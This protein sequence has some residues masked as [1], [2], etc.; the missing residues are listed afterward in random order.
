MFALW[1]C[2]ETFALAAGDLPHFVTRSWQTDNGLPQSTATAVLQARDGYLWVGTYN[3]LMRYDGVRFVLFDYNNT[4]ELHDKGITCL[5]EAADGTLWIGHSSGGVTRYKNGHFER[6]EANISWGEGAIRAIAMDEMGD[7]WLLNDTG[8]LARLRDGLVLTPQTGPLNGMAQM[9][10]SEHGTI[11][12][13]RAG[14]LSQ[15]RASRLVVLEAG[16]ADN[17]VQ[18]V[19]VSR[20]G[21]LWVVSGGRLRQW[22]GG[23]WSED[24]G[25]VPS[26]L[27]P[28]AQL[29]E[30][31]DGWLAAA[32][33]DHG[34]YLSRPRAGENGVQFGRTNGFPSDWVTSL[35]EDRERDLWVGTAGAGLQVVRAAKVQTVSPPDQ[36]QGRA[37]LSVSTSGR[38]GALWI[39]SEG[40]GIYRFYE[41]T[42]KNFGVRAGLDNPYIWSV[43]EDEK[44]DLWAAS[45]GGGLYQRRND[46]FVTA[47]GLEGIVMPMAAI[48][49]SR[50]GGL[51]IGT[52]AGLL[53][54][55]DGQAT[56][57][58]QQGRP[59]GRSVRTVM[60]DS[61]GTVWFGTSGGGLGCLTNG[62]LR[63][64]RT[65]DGLASDYVTCLHRDDSGS[66]WIGTAGGLSRLKH[67][68][69]ATIKQK[70]GLP[71]EHICEIEEDGFGF[72][73]M[74]SHNGIIRV[75][76][77]D[78]DR[79][80]NGQTIKIT[81]L[82][83]GLGDGMPTLE[84]SGGLQP[85]GCKTSDGRLWFPT[86]KGLVTIE[87]RD[88]QTNSLPP[89]VVIESLTVDEKRVIEGAALL[90][91][92]IPAGR[93]RFEFKYTALSF[94][95]PEKVQFKR[96]LEG[97]ESEWVQAGTA[98]SANYSYVPPGH[99]RF[100][101]TA[102]N[103]D[104]VWNE[105]GAELAFTVLPFFWQT[106]FF[107]ILAGVCMALVVVGL[108]WLDMRRRMQ[109]KLQ[110]LE[111]QRAVERERVRIAKDIHDDLG[112]SLTRISLLSESA[113]SE[114]NNPPQV[115][116]ELD[117]IFDTARDLTRTMDEI[118]WAVNPMHDTL[119][120]L[121]NY[122][123]KFAQDYLETA[124]ILCR[125]DL[126]LELPTWPLSAD[127]R[128]HLF[129]AFKEAL[130]NAVKH[131]RASEVHI[132]LALEAEALVLVVKDNGVGFALQPVPGRNGVGTNRLANGNGLDN[133]RRR[134][135]EIGG[136]CDV[137]SEAG[138]GTR[139]RFSVPIPMPL[140]ES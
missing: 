100:R 136:R 50:Q 111:K 98:R 27:V 105:Q 135:S 94:A 30:T 137:Q 42:W 54:Y 33:S 40:A 110:V 118:V 22:K 1:F 93:H 75:S 101:V 76:K 108:V 120:S 2:G 102:C 107:W 127:V 12:V 139:V 45:W 32:T 96:Q 77:A 71:D 46:H 134:L 15:L 80:A 13:A 66:L 51:W 129:L 44:G 16:T 84:C 48:L 116:A 56:W 83:Y 79:C 133:M 128:H 92:R 72:F 4:P 89:P 29:L 138:R 70:Q 87:P 131:A 14:C 25:P 67:G 3:G 24:L 97:L 57:Y 20:D 47:P 95:A 5:F 122:L 64:F 37:I 36:W 112:S 125:L 18:G 60:E 119:D 52:L 90:P 81:C 38:D 123:Q 91:M 41:G 43:V 53:R 124:G 59:G 74:S 85:A 26:N 82:T 121:A 69:L 39:G 49:C 113:R 103:N 99:Y 9:V 126:P 17:Y 114:L 78:L 19:G 55:Q 68:F 8:L 28:L 115:A 31:Q 73:W 86:S 88:V 61:D 23:K 58:G 104:E 34:F 35:C 11:W 130:H 6:M 109:R 140:A 117:R 132:S 21:G 7:I 65:Q 106:P 63:W 10:R 62:I